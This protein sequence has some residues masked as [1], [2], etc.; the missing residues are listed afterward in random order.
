MVEGC[1]DH[2]VVGPEDMLTDAQSLVIK[3]LRLLGIIAASRNDNEQVTWL[4]SLAN[5][6][7]IIFMK[8]FYGLN[9]LIVNI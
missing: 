1:G 9:I 5:H 7:V 8:I 4:I 3:L 6:L 2:D